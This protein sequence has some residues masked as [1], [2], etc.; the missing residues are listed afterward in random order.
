MQ[1][2]EGW[3][4][5]KR[6]KREQKEIQRNQG[7]S[8]C[9]SVTIVDTNLFG[10]RAVGNYDYHW[11]HTIR[12]T[13]L[14]KW[15]SK[16]VDGASGWSD[17]MRRS[18]CM[19]KLSFFLQIGTYF[20]VLCKLFMLCSIFKI[21]CSSKILKIEMKFIENSKSFENCSMLWCGEC[22][23]CRLP[24]PKW[25]VVGLFNYNLHCFEG[26]EDTCDVVGKFPRLSIEI[27][28]SRQHPK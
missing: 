14:G 19:E 16:C 15:G 3:R 17:S 20:I 21:A 10:E 8:V 24:S 4:S 5:K 27:I 11:R 13:E 18:H 28:L 23:L 26:V 12:E 7:V 22:C 2:T 1:E 25:T 6:K 9:S